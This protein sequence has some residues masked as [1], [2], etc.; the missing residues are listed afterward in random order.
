MEPRTIERTPATGSGNRHF[1][2]PGAFGGTVTRRKNHDDKRATSG[3][4]THGVAARLAASGA[5][6]PQLYAVSEA[7]PAGPDA[8]TLR[9][10]IVDDNLLAR[11]SHAARVKLHEKLQQ[12]YFPPG[13]PDHWRLLVSALRRTTLDDQRALVA[14]VALNWNDLLFRSLNTT[15]L[16]SQLHHAG[17]SLKVEDVLEAIR[18]LAETY[19]VIRHW[20]Q[21]TR[22][23]VAQHYLGALRDFGFARGKV[24][25]YLTRPH[26][27]PEA[28]LFAC[29]LL[30]AEGIPAPAIVRHPIFQALGLTLDETVKA[31]GDLDRR[32][33][34]RFRVQGGVV[35]LRL[36]QSGEQ[37]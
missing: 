12:R 19:P 29:E 25:K 16:F 23:S 13:R 15:W 6:L 37:L 2:E 18:K 28:L 11:P 21:S 35:H 1:P 7:L 24:K 31:L 33:L 22:R 36:E 14:C 27:G 10:L 3:S 8:K 32:G 34:L 9:R 30:V 20:R 5:M 17:L 26:I 4:S